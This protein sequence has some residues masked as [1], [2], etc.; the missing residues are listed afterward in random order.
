VTSVTGFFINTKRTQDRRTE[1]RAPGAVSAREAKLR[2]E[3]KTESQRSRDGVITPGVSQGTR[4]VRERK[5]RPA[6]PPLNPRHKLRNEPKA[7]TTKQ[8][9]TSPSQHL[10]LRLPLHRWR[11]SPSVTPRETRMGLD[12]TLLS[13]QPQ[14]PRST[15]A[16][17]Y[18]T[19]PSWST[20]SQP[21]KPDI[22][23][24]PGGSPWCIPG[25]AWWSPRREQASE[26]C[27]RFSQS[28]KSRTR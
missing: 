13:C 27:S 14:V 25:M 16:T 24:P 8:P 12:T 15:N 10:S 1:P 2:N 22:A 20:R 7:P 18:Q 17:N 26:A 5:K 19:N 11:G 3:P 28:E 9:V 21:Y 23:S 4:S 6:W